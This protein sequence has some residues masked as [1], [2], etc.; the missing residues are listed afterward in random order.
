M[1]LSFRTT[2]MSEP[3]LDIVIRRIPVRCIYL[4]EL[5]MMFRNKIRILDGAAFTYRLVLAEAN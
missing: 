3:I 4:I 5:S 2:K 1:P